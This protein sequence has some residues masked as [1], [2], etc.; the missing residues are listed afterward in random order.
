MICNMCGVY[1][2]HD[3]GQLIPPKEK[4]ADKS[5]NGMILCSKCYKFIRQIK[6]EVKEDGTRLIHVFNT[7][8]IN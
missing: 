5:D 1:P 2:I 6:I 4:Y 3:V 8:I 7:N